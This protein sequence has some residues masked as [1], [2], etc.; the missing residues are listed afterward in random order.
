MEGFSDQ[1]SSFGKLKGEWID[2]KSVEFKSMGLDHPSFL[3]LEEI[4]Q[5]PRSLIKYGPIGS[6]P[7]VEKL[8]KLYKL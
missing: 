4:I 5:V 2:E 1:A 6:Y 7:N 3:R 8:L